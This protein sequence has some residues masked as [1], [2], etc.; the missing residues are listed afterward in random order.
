MT[1]KS[2]QVIQPCHVL[3][4]VDA[5]PLSRKLAEAQPFF[6]GPVAQKQYTDR[7]KVGGKQT[8]IVKKRRVFLHFHFFPFSPSVSLSPL[9]LGSTRSSGSCGRRTVYVIIGRFDS[10][11]AIFGYRLFSGGI[12]N[13]FG[14]L[15]YHVSELS[16]IQSP[17]LYGYL[18]SDLASIQQSHHRLR[19]G[20]SNWAGS[21]SIRLVQLE[22][23]FN[24]IRF[25][26]PSQY[27]HYHRS[28]YDAWHA[29]HGARVARDG[30]LQRRLILHM[31]FLSC[32]FDSRRA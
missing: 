11:I 3:L 18:R 20:N 21:I 25:W 4:P 16:V 27:Q 6:Y 13:S 26:R 8:F 31:R 10:K 22:C 5:L 30:S 29:R 9:R 7:N 1:V 15:A 28:R 12:A 19:P 17:N 32:L 23:S 2:S 24:H 14:G